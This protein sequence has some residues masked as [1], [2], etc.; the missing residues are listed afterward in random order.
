MNP[1]L[2]IVTVGLC[3]AVVFGGLS[4]LR[5]EGLSAQFAFEVLG[6][7][8]LV[9]VGALLTSS[10]VNPIL[11]LVLVYLLSMRGRLLVDLANLLSS[12]GRQKNAISLL[13]FALKLF[14][15]RSTRLIIMVNMG[16]VQLRRQSPASAQALFEAV[17]QEAE[18]GGLGVKYEA[19]S[20]YNLGLAL[21]RQGKQAEAV[22]H[23]NEAVG[24]FPNSIYSKAAQHALEQRRQR[25]GKPASL[26]E[27]ME[28]DSS[29]P[30]GGPGNY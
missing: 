7:T 19:A 21:Q 16:I 10:T 27:D 26:A 12:R 23:F 22:R 8:A 24:I 13:Q 5:R 6:I 18:A 3:Y 29:E 25:T 11:F 1:H 30:Q 28:G 17:L 2:L 14:P 15:D 20:Q 4:L 9:E